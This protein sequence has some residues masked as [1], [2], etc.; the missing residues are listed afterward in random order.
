MPMKCFPDTRR[1]LALLFVASVLLVWL[2]NNPL[3]RLRALEGSV[4]LLALWRVF[5]PYKPTK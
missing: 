4:I 3:L 5:A 1:V 2:A